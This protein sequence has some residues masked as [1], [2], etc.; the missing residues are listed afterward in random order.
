MACVFESVPRAVQASHHLV[1]VHIGRRAGRSEV[2][3]RGILPD[4]E[5]RISASYGSKEGVLGRLP[6][7]PDS[8]QERIGGSCVRFARRT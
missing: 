7:V 2:N 3:E 4:D 5:K 6:G 1:G 8:T